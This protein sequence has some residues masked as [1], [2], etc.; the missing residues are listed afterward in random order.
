MLLFLF[1]AIACE[2]DEVV[3]V[4][5]S[6][7]I[8]DSGTP[9]GGAATD[10]GCDP[11]SAASPETPGATT[12]RIEIVDYDFWDD[13]DQKRARVRNAGVNF[14]TANIPP[15]PIES[16]ALFP[17]VP[18]D[19]CA[20]VDI[21]IP[22]DS[23]GPARNVGNTITI[24][25]EAGTKSVLL[26]R[27]VEADGIRYE[28]ATQEDLL[29]FF[30]PNYLAF[31]ERWTYATEGDATANIGPATAVVEPFDDFALLE[32]MVSS[33]STAVP[34]DGSVAWTST[35]TKGLFSILLGRLLDENDVRYAICNVADDGSFTIPPD[36]MVEFGPTPGLPFDVIVSRA[37][38]EPFCNEGVVSGLI[39]HVTAYIGAGVLP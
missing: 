38:A 36:V 30:D 35:G 8:A 5:D 1:F 14:F 13:I 31:D 19:Q 20:V 28:W 10:A 33:S 7:V 23:I 17:A 34:V 12:G 22:M 39:L 24:S 11:L 6:G 32:P 9:D 25:N 37:A 27:T 2:D 21:P 3:P 16:A 26:E 15:I 4:P 18:I 29:N